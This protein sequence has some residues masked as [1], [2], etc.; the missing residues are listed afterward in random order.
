MISIAGAGGTGLA[1]SA[2]VRECL[3]RGLET[4]VLSRHSPGVQAPA[5][6]AGASYVQVDILSGHGLEDALAGADVVIDTLNGQN[7]AARAVLTLGAGNLLRAAGAAG[8][9]RATLLSIVNV[10]RSAFSYYRAKAEQE[11]AYAGSALESVTVRS[12]QFHDLVAGMF[13]SGRRLGIV[14]VFRG[15]SFQSISTAD[16]ARLLVDAATGPVQGTH[17]GFSAGGPKVQTM[18]E[19]ANEW[20]AAT[21]SAGRVVEMPLPGA[22]GRFLREGLNLV[23]EA[24]A[25][26]ET[27]RE[28]LRRVRP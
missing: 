19:L 1:G 15:T 13:A 20:R 23:P 28:W 14:P 17:S 11:R 3:R 24:A 27:F 2:V 4:R 5:Y 22:F 25:G 9:R 8:V 26:R 6:A 21:G 10:D 18:R 12:T 16:V 7:R